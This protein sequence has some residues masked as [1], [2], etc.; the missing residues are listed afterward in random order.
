MIN[1]SWFWFISSDLFGFEIVPG[2]SIAYL[3]LDFMNNK[4]LTLFYTVAII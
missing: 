4:W 3:F 2:I 1:T